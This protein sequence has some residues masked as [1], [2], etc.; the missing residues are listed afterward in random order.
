MSAAFMKKLIPVLAVD[1]RFGISR[2]GDIPWHIPQDLRFFKEITTRHDKKINAVIMGRNT[3]EQIPPEHRPLGNRCNII[4][5][6]TLKK[7]DGCH[8]YDSLQALYENRDNHD[9]ENYY[10]CG[11]SSL[12][13]EVLKTCETAYLTYIRKDYGTDNL[14]DSNLL[15]SRL[16]NSEFIKREFVDNYDIYYYKLS[17]GEEIITDNW[18]SDYISILSRLLSAPERLTRN[19]ITQSSFME[20]LTI[21]C[22]SFPVMTTKKLFFRGVVEELL[23]FIKGYTDANILDEKGVKIW[24]G[25]TTREFLDNRGLN[26]AVGDM[27]PMY[28]WQWRH[29]GAV[30]KG[31]DHDYTGEGFDQL[32]DV[33]DKIMNDP[34]NRRIMMTSFDPSAVTK[35]VLAPCHS[36][37]VQFYVSDDKLSMSMYQRSADIFHGVPFNIASSA[38]LLHLIAYVTKKTPDMLHIMLGDT[39]LYRD[40]IT[41]ATTQISNEPYVNTKKLL[42]NRDINEIEDAHDAI[43]LLENI[44]YND[45]LLLGYRSYSRIDAPFVV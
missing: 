40:H 30:Y 5:S 22:R 36:I 11:G 39:H 6:R 26:Y 9:V 20:K 15:L 43:N 28:G 16:I 24:N 34:C 45:L 31:K 18:E 4:I 14:I 17:F 1:A 8:V 13:N 32:Y 2:G 27:G 21:S 38:L 29:F 19:S 12:Y 25:N 23:F 44:T 10:V 33:I 37:V 7:I 35:S 3:W 41:A 42:I